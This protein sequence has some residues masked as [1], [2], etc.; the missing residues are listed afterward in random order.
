MNIGIIQFTLFG[1]V[2]LL[3]WLIIWIMTLIYQGKRNQWV[4]FVLTLIFN[5]VLLIYWIV[6]TFEPKLKRKHK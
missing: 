3:V 6:W 2:F 5:I 4:W 1:M